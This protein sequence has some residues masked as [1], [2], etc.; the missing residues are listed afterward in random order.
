MDAAN[1]KPHQYPEGFPSE[2]ESK[3]ERPFHILDPLGNDPRINNITKYA[4]AT[5]TI[6]QD[7]F[8]NTC[9]KGTVD[10]LAV[11]HVTLVLL[12][13]AGYGDILFINKT[14]QAL[15]KANCQV[16]IAILPSRR[17]QEARNIL[18]G[19]N[20]HEDLVIVTSKDPQSK[21]LDS[22][23]V[24]IGPTRPEDGS[25]VKHFPT[26]TDVPTQLIL[27]YGYINDPMETKEQFMN[28]IISAGIGPGEL[29]IF[30]DKGLIKPLNDEEKAKK[31]QSISEEHPEKMGL[32]LQEKTSHEYLES[33]KLFFGYAHTSKS[34][35]KFVSTIALSEKDN[36][37]K[38]IDIVI[39]WRSESKGLQC[40]F[41]D[42]CKYN[43]A[44]LVSAGISKVEIVTSGGVESE[45]ISTNPEGKVLRI[46]N[47]YP[48]QNKTMQELQDVS[49]N[50]TL[51]TGDQ[52][53]NEAI[54]RPDKIILYEIMPWKVNF[55]HSTEGLSRS[56]PLVYNVMDAWSSSS[57]QK[58]A[59]AV[60]AVTTNSKE[61]VDNSQI[62]GF[63]KSIVLN[64]SL[65][66]SL[67]K[68]VEKLSA[69]K[70]DPLLKI[71][72][73][74]IEASIKQAFLLPS[75]IDRCINHLQKTIIFYI[76]GSNSITSIKEELPFI[77]YYKEIWNS[78]DTS[79]LPENIRTTIEKG[80][81]LIDR[82][83]NEEIIN[84][85]EN[86]Y[87]LVP[88]L[89]KLRRKLLPL[90]QRNLKALA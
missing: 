57:S 58:T 33:T 3:E 68:E 43:V 30:T 35:S 10:P 78:M 37:T 44:E 50:L 34:M 56:Y 83:K 26:L 88:Q 80:F 79:T 64:H 47:P 23:C 49:E 60:S 90:A 31:L 87:P 69:L 13:K 28:F 36:P 89:V 17:D 2:I 54:L 27:E 1:S 65:E 8:I 41:G 32:I 7:N 42:K 40:E 81:S 46:I 20:P 74:A 45:V 55:Y 25:V 6:N 70:K 76:N 4:S 62:R 59:E 29:G 77:E 85:A 12:E 39:P 19:L 22:D 71:K 38:N 21:T 52:S 5:L 53:W 9:G 15:L 73:D 24:I 61:E 82:M 11:K 86:R 48:F 51:T 16:T 63:H 14:A 72:Y 66:R 84:S 18:R 75:L 67:E